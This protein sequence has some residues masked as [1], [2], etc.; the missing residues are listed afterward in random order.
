MFLALDGRRFV[1]PWIGFW[2]IGEM[3]V[4]S[5]SRE[6]PELNWIKKIQLVGKRDVEKG[7]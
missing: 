4:I 6:M 2:G 3:N 7:T 1:R 5:H